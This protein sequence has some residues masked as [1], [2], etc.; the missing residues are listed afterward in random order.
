[1][2]Q[3][4]QFLGP[5]SPTNNETPS[6]KKLG[7]TSSPRLL[8]VQTPEEKALADAKL[9]RLNAATFKDQAQ[10]RLANLESAKLQVTKRAQKP[11]KGRKI[12]G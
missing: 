12:G 3:S 6:P 8:K 7:P 2:F 10:G 11:R 4:R 1:M 5:S 9:R